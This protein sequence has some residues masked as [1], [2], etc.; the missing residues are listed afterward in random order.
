[1]DNTND[2]PIFNIYPILI[3]LLK[4]TISILIKVGIIYTGIGLTALIISFLPN[5]LFIVVTVA[6]ASGYLIYPIDRQICKWCLVW[7]DE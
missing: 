4:F 2:Y 1:M 7:S 3:F 5:E 6:V